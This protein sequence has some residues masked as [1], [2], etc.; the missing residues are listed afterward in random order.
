MTDWDALRR[1]LRESDRRILEKFGDHIGRDVRTAYD[2][3]GKPY[4]YH[5]GTE[6]VSEL[7]WKARDMVGQSHGLPAIVY[8]RPDGSWYL[9]QTKAGEFV[10]QQKEALKHKD[11]Q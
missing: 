11:G 5:M 10:M 2:K 7:M 3:R 8:C 6:K 1:D 9:D 4:Q